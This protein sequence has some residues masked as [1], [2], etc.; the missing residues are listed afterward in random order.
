M[1]ITNGEE[2]IMIQDHKIDGYHYYDNH[3]IGVNLTIYLSCNQ[4]IHLYESD[5]CKNGYSKED[6]LRIRD[7]IALIICGV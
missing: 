7:Q 1:K 3:N 4:Q 2:V 6:I 5:G